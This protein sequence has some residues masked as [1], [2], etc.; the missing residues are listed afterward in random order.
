MLA[1][2]S[3][4]CQ[5]VNLKSSSFDIIMPLHKGLAHIHSQIKPW[6]F[7]GESFTLTISPLNPAHVENRHRISAKGCVNAA[8]VTQALRRSAWLWHISQTVYYNVPWLNSASLHWGKKKKNNNRKT[9]YV[10]L[11]HHNSFHIFFFHKFH[12][13][14]SGKFRRATWLNH[15]IGVQVRG[16][17]QKLTGL[18]GGCLF[19]MWYMGRWS[20]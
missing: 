1:A 19:S 7:F 12:L 18:A 17:N 20:K 2:V 3:L 9:V 13:I 6:L 8:S 16:R 5:T 4:V 11:E 14:T 10:I 15:F